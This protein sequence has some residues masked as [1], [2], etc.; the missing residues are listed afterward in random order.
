LNRIGRYIFRQA[1]GSTIIVIGVLLLIL[2]SNQFAETL[3]D[4]A[5]DLLPRDA[6]LKV[7]GF[8]FVQMLSLLAPVGLLLGVLLALARLNRDSEMAALASCGIGPLQLLRPIGLLSI[9]LALAVSW[10]A[11]FAAPA[12]SLEVEQIRIQAQTEMELGALTSGRFSTV[13]GGTMVVY[14][15]SAR[16][17]ILE[18]VFIEREVDGRIEAV[19]AREGERVMN[20]ETGESLLRLRD[21]RRYVGTPG[22]ARFSLGLFQE[23]GIPIRFEATVFEQ[24]IEAR[25]T[26]SLLRMADAESRAELEW[27]MASPLSILVLALLAVPLGRS[28]PREGKYARVGVGLLIYIVYANSL[29]IARVWVERDAIPSW[30]GLW[31]VHAVVALLAIAMLL[32]QSGAGISERPEHGERVEPTG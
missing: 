6:V 4:A 13:D 21:G 1:L 9:G 3:G 20:P 11:L 14:A 25:S 29:S 24:A 2:M 17:D 23:H 10:L 7:F 18:D 16:G 8:Q 22:E 30:L 28:S 5:A 27:R 12:A 19:V 31:W 32:R 26:A 15:A